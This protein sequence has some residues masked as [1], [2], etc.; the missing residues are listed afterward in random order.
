MK[1][2]ET[3]SRAIPATSNLPHRRALAALQ[4]VQTEKGL[5]EGMEDVMT[6]VE[7]YF[8][9][10]GIDYIIGGGYLE[11]VATIAMLSLRLPKNDPDSPQSLLIQRDLLQGSERDVIRFYDRRASVRA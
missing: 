4:L 10:L 7:S 5:F 6:W 3:K 9:A 8:V 11:M 2:A 1:R